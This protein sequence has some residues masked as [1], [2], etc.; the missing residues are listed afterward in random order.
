MHTQGEDPLSKQVLFIPHYSLNQHAVL[1]ERSTDVQLSGRTRVSWVP[2]GQRSFSQEAWRADPNS[3]VKQDT[4]YHMTSCSVI[5]YGS[6]L[7]EGDLL[8]R[9]KMSIRR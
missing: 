7:E 2:L 8:L 1:N 6:W 3:P 4:P 9:S 5:R